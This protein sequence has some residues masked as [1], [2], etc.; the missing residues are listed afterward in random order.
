MRL[1]SLNIETDKHLER[2]VPYVKDKNLD[3][4][5]MQEVLDKDLADLENAFDMQSLFTPLNYL[6]REKDNP[7]LGI[8]TF[9]KLP[10]TKHFDNYYYGDAANLPSI[11][12]G[13][14]EKMARAI[15]VTEVLKDGVYYCIVNTHFTWSP[16]GKP[17]KVQHRD[18]ER[19][20]ASLEKIPEL[21]LCG[22][23][24]APRGTAI[25][26][27]IASRYKD[28]IPAHVTTTLDKNWHYAGELKLV[29]D[30]IFTTPTYQVDTIKIVNDLSD[31]CGLLAEISKIN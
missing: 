24:N 17:N 8:A 15:S 21:I 1:L 18:L 31:H 22:D 16:H 7:Q 20:L 26:D 4:I 30:G 6:C 23:F 14:P 3:V 28:N 10:I 27:I 9:T 13:E 2:F 19:M 5:V 12:H 29:V 11:Q 25:F